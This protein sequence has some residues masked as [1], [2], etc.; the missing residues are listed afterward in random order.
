[1]FLVSLLAKG[2]LFIQWI[3]GIISTLRNCALILL[4]MVV[5]FAMASCGGF[6]Y[7]MG[8]G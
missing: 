4:V 7:L 6:G 2:F 8:S 5:L 3:G 1:M